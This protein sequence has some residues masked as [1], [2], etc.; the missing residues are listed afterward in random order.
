MYVW[1][2]KRK[3]KAMKRTIVVVFFTIYEDNMAR[4]NPKSRGQ[5]M[6]HLAREK[7][8]KIEAGK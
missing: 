6:V 8:Q 1:A 2:K 4:R 5:M 3:P 7:L